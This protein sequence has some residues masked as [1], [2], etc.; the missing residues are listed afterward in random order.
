MINE[1]ANKVYDRVNL[2]SK[3]EY[4]LNGT[5][6]EEVG[7]NWTRK[8]L[9]Y[10]EQAEIINPEDKNVRIALRFFYERLKMENKLNALKEKGEGN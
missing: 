6:L 8:A 9:P 1:Q 5:D 3:E 4:M 7:H 2:M 10:M